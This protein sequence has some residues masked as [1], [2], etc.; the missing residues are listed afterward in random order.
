VLSKATQK[1]GLLF[2]ELISAY[3]VTKSD[4]MGMK[5]CKLQHVERCPSVKMLLDEVEAGKA[6]E[7]LWELKGLEP[8][9]A[10]AK[11]GMQLLEFVQDVADPFLRHLL[12]RLKVAFEESS[13]IHL[14][15][16][17]DQMVLPSNLET[18]S[19]AWKDH[20]Q[21]QAKSKKK[22]LTFSIPAQTPAERRAFSRS[23]D[24]AVEGLN[25][26]REQTALFKTEQEA[27]RQLCG[28]RQ[29][30]R[31]KKGLSPIQTI[32]DLVDNLQDKSQPHPPAKSQQDHSAEAPLVSIVFDSTVSLMCPYHCLVLSIVYS[33]PLGTADVERGF[34][35]FARIQTRNRKSLTSPQLNNLMLVSAHAP[36]CN[37]PKLDDFIELA[38][39]R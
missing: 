11:F 5:D 6:T 22:K 33:T 20:E 3:E 31:I 12:T 30:G 14:L 32:A 38:L 16:A 9:A 28:A 29:L 7:Y 36:A 18:I 19:R 35:A 8:A 34:S 4:L 10:A 37:D 2:S 25:L 17:M 21:Q 23:L 13:Q 15:A 24:T 1:T 26:S 27:W 39:A